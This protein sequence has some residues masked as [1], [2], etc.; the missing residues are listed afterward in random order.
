MTPL[1]TQ[2]QSRANDNVPWAGP[3]TSSAVS[4]RLAPQLDQRAVM[5]SMLDAGVSTRRGI[6]C[7]HREPAYA[8]YASQ[9]LPH[10]VAAQEQCVLLPLYIQM[11]D[12]EQARVVDQLRAACEQR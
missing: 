4:V 10:S 7:T 9:P 12:E 5:Q 1:L 3:L 8:S 2:T 6:M 11:T